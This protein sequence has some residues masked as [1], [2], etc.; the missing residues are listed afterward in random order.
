MSPES[1]RALDSGASTI[2]PTFPIRPI[3]KHQ[4][5]ASGYVT[6]EIAFSKNENER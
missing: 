1:R 4:L 5:A 6:S 2:H 3:I